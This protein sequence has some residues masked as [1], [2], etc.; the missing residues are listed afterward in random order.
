M[1]RKPIS[2]RQQGFTLIELVVVIVILGILS[3]TAIPK[4]IGVDTA[5]K[6]AVL[7]GGSAALQSAAVIALANNAAGGSATPKPSFTSVKSTATLDTNI[8]ISSGAC[9][10]AVLH[11]GGTGGTP[12]L[13]LPD[14]GSALGL[15]S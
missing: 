11:Y 2:R 3:A 1:K 15:C 13:A 12:T 5:A 8:Y 4:F 10:G 9:S 7:Q 14:L 6:T